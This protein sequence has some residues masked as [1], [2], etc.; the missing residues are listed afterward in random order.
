MVS[1]DVQ[2]YW[3]IPVSVTINE[4]I[5]LAKYYSTPKSHKYINGIL[6]NISK[7]LIKEHKLM[8]K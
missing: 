2:E 1:G 6:D 3:N 4:D 8:K 7:R 5:E